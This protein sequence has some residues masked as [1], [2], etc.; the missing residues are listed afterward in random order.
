[1]VIYSVHVVLK[2]INPQKREGIQIT[3]S[4]PLQNKQIVPKHT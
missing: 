1:M 2:N 3:D 4:Y